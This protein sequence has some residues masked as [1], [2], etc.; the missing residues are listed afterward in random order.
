MC[1]LSLATLSF[2]VR[3]DIPSVPYVTALDWF[4]IMCYLFLFASLMEFTAVHYFTKVT[5]L[6]QLFWFYSNCLNSKIWLKV[7]FGDFQATLLD[8]FDHGNESDV[9]LEASV[10]KSSHL[11]NNFN[12]NYHKPKTFKHYLNNFWR[13]I[14][15]DPHFK[16][17]MTKR[18][19]HKGINS[20]SKCDRVSRILF[21][22]FF[23]LLNILYWYNYY[24]NV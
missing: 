16:K 22:A 5:H 8:S 1:V 24:K 7:G 21:P 17:E 23:L 2:D 3:N 20:V 14:I 13:C 9:T 19:H 11:N 18:A 6:F 4:L 15:S 12:Q 10:S